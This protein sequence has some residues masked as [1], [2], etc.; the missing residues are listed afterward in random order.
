MS[1]LL[2]R[3]KRERLSDLFERALALPPEGQAAF[4]EEACG[5]DAELYAEL[6]S[7]LASPA[8]PPDFLERMPQ[9]LLEAALGALSE[10]S[11]PAGRVVGHYAILDSLGGG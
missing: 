2:G 5:C 1:D 11:L 10:E 8:V 7:L 3:A 4:V 6:T 9:Q